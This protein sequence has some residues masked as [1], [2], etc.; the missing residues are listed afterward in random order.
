MFVCKIA[1]ALLLTVGGEAIAQ[2]SFWTNSTIPAAPEVTNDAA[3]VTLGLK[4]SSDVPGSVLAVRFYKGVHNTGQHVGNLWSSAGTKL[5]TVTFS[6]ETASGWQQAAFSSPINI[7]AKTTYVISYLDPKGHYADDQSYAW[8]T[9]NAAPLHVSGTSPG[10]YAYGSGARFPTGTWNGSNYWV[11]LVFAPASSSTYSISG[12]VSGSAATLTLSG[13]ASGLTTADSAGNYSFST[14]KNGLY[15]V[16]PSQSGYTFT[17]STASVSINSAS[18]TGVNFKSTAVPVPLPHSVSLSWTASTSP[19]I[20]G[21]NLY[22]TGAAAG[23]Y[24]QLNA[25]P[26]A[27]SSYVD[28]KVTAGQ[29]YFYVATAVDGNSNQSDYSNQA[30][31]TTPTP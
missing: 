19:N 12:N 31:A 28:T 3:S 11:D 5:A 24:T 2:T 25:S 22:R 10:V 29:T 17:P 20:V 7:A 9:R 13:V 14:L 8:S 30:T 6:G 1:A 23:P 21:Y 15:V 16:A 4:F 26:I 27:A 18:V